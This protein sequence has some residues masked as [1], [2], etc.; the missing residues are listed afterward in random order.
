MK[1]LILNSLYPTPFHPKIVGGAEKSVRHL[2][3]ALVREGH[4]VEVIRAIAPCAAPT[5]EEL[6][7]VV[8]HGAPSRNLYWPFDGRTRPAW[9]RVLWHLID[10]WGVTPSIV[11]ERLDAFRPDVV[12]TN[13]LAGLTTGVWRLARARGVRV[14]HTLRDY[15]L[16]CPRAKAY[17]DGRNCERVCRDCAVL[18]QHRRAAT[19]LPNAVVGN[20]FATLNLHLN[21]GLFSGVPVRTAIGSLPE[22]SKPLPPRDRSED[23]RTVF[24]FIGRITEEKG[25]ELLAEAYG[26]LPAGAA[27]LV[28]AGETDPE[29]QARLTKAAGGRDIR[30]LGF[31]PPEVFYRAVDIVVAPSLWH[32]PLPRSVID[33]ISYGRPVIGS[34]RGGTPEAMGEPPFGWIFDPDEP[35]GLERIMHHSHLISDAHSKVKPQTVSLSLSEYLRVYRGAKPTGMKY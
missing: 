7:G 3:E 29:V 23:P 12:H 18:T 25:V 5:R 20:S 22:A 6:N 1:I 10:D 15:Y 9:K 26:R 31:V 33:A 32:E 8:I 35:G 11:R 19:S 30:F 28:I 21:Q 27:H 4:V 16:L 17:K 2:A 14:V 24:G 34:N 13:T